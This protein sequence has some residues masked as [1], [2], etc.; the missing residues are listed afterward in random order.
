[1]YRVLNSIILDNTI[2]TKKDRYNNKTCRGNCYFDPVNNGSF[3]LCNI[4]ECATCSLL[5]RWD[6]LWALDIYIKFCQI[7]GFCIEKYWQYVTII[8]YF[9]VWRL[10]SANLRVEG[11]CD[12]LDEIWK[13]KFFKN[14]AKWQ[15][16]WLIKEEENIYYGIACYGLKFI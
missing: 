7:T 6:A 2:G 14:Q 16:T 13:S 10:K 12:N 3:D 11:S 15:V 4:H 1:M 8:A 5:S 9:G